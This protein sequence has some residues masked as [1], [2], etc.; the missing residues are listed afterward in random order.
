MSN[1]SEILAKRRDGSKVNTYT[2]TNQTHRNHGN[3]VRPS[4]LELLT[5]CRLPAHLYHDRSALLA[6][7][8]VVDSGALRCSAIALAT[9]EDA[10]VSVAI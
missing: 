7:R 1:L 4:N 10:H 2:K 9:R 3:D 6:I 8:I 5:K